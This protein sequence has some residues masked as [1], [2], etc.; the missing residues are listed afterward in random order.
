MNLQLMIIHTHTSWVLELYMY[1]LMCIMGIYFPD[2]LHAYWG[3][4]V[5]KKGVVI[6][7]NVGEQYNTFIKYQ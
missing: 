6:N 1:L 7:R 2:K 5:M 4:V 3:I